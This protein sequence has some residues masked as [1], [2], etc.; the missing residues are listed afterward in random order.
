[1]RYAPT[2]VIVPVGIVLMAI[3]LMGGLPAAARQVPV[4]FP[5]GTWFG[6]GEPH[7]KSEMWVARMG[8]DGSFKVHFRACRKGQAMDHF[9]AGRWRLDGDLE[10]IAIAS[11]NGLALPRRDQY[12]IMAHDA[13]H[14]TYRYL[15]TG[16]VFT[17]YRV[18]DN[19]PMPGCDLVS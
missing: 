2:P 10:T 6:Q 13:R 18:A 7:D 8:P 15:R 16:F 14:Q 3:A 5:V 17:S 19:Y 1:M 9:E 12:R 11:V 4:T